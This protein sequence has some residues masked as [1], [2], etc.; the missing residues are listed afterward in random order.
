M[1]QVPSIVGQGKVARGRTSSLNRLAPFA[2]SS[3][4]LFPRGSK[5]EPP[6]PPPNAREVNAFFQVCSNANIFKMERFTLGW[7]LRPPL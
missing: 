1:K 2:Y 4:S 3:E 6:L 5:S 7:N